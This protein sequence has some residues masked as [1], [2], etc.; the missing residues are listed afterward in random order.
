MKTH[1]FM[2]N[3][4][5]T[6]EELAPK[7]NR[8]HL[9]AIALWR[10]KREDNLFPFCSRKAHAYALRK[11]RE[12]ERANGELSNDEWAAAYESFMSVYI[13]NLNNW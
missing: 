11:I 10:A 2:D 12:L 9:K 13:N 4:P 6:L 3:M 8:Y 1:D 7:V 5:G